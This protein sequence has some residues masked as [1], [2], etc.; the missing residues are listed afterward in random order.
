[1]FGSNEKLKI[2]EV[3]G[4]PAFMKENNCKN[5]EVSNLFL[6]ESEHKEAEEGED[7]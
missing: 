6:G 2:I 5:S 7:V 3:E 1:M 4:L